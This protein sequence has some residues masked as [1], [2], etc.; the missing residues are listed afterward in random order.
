MISSTLLRDNTNEQNIPLKLNKEG[1]SYFRLWSEKTHQV[2][3]WYVYVD[4]NLTGGFL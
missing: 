2:S 1:V 3:V 4:Y